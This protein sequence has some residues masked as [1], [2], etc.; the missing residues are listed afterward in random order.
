MHSA[1]HKGIN[2][3]KVIVIYTH[4]DFNGS[5]LGAG[6]LQL[7]TANHGLWGNW[8]YTITL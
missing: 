8:K 5:V 1:I 7:E 4:N 3:R 6:H 2:V